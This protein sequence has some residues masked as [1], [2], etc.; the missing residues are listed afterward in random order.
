MLP[1]PEVLRDRI[2]RIIAA[3]RFPFVDQTNWDEARR[4]LTN[5]RTEKQ[6]AVK[7]PIG[8]LYPSVVV[9]NPD[10]GIREIGEVEI[11]VTPGL[12]EKWR[13]LSEATGMGE[14]YKKLFIY[15][16]E[17]EGNIAMRFL[18]E[19]RIEYAGLREW[20]IKEGTLV[21]R[22][23]VTPDMEYDHRVSELVTTGW[24]GS[25]RPA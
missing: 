3:T 23:V 14:R 21:T 24:Q 9:L 19:G 12:V 1:P 25:P 22:P 4:T 7:T 15:V 13:V 16:P 11:E 6:Y 20:C 5:T 2:T 17:A 10:G 18:D 8:T